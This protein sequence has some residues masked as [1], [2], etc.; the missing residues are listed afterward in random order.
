MDL[1]QWCK[2]EAVCTQNRLEF[3]AIGVHVFRPVP[4]HEAEIE[5]LFAVERTDTANTSAEAV[6]E[7]WEPGKRSELQDPQAPGCA[8]FP[9]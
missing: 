7:P 6:N 3:A 2:Y 4:F 1:L 5:Q 8:E 9:R